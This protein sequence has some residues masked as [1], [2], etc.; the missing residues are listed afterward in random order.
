MARYRHEWKHEISLS[1]CVGLRQRLRA[2]AEPDPHARDGRYRIRSLYFDN[3]RDKALREKLDGVD[4]REKFRIRY[5]DGDTSL[6]HLEKK[7]KRNGLGTKS[8][9]P[10]TAREAQAIVDGDWGWMPGSGRDV[11]VELYSKM[12]CQGL[13]PRT[14]VDYTR[15]PFVYGPGNVRVTLDYGLRTG[16]GCT[17]FLDPDCVTV[18]VRGPAALLEVKWDAYLP[19]V[20]QAAVQLPGRRAGA[21]SKYAACRIYG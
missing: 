6:I 4:R 7:S 21:F 13:R 12:R 16:L 14:I 1:D 8:S 20:I 9:S 18:P 10:L 11:V 19:A 15:E 2:V 3:L 5:Y 17:D